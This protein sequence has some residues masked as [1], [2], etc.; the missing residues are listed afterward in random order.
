MTYDSR[1]LL[2]RVRGRLVGQS[3]MCALTR[4]CTPYARSCHVLCMDATRRRRCTPTRGDYAKRMRCFLQITLAGHI[5]LSTEAICA[6]MMPGYTFA[7][8]AQ[9]WYT[10]DA[11]DAP[12]G[13]AARSVAGIRCANWKLRAA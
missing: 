10:Q 9:A 8:L 13:C 11:G 1:Q 2:G 7:W 12:P 3:L 4:P 6:D 5:G